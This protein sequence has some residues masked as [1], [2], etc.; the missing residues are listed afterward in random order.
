MNVWVALRTVKKKTVQYLK[1]HHI[2]DNA[3]TF[4]VKA[5]S[6]ATGD[7]NFGGAYPFG[8]T[9]GDIANAGVTSSAS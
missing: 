6:S 4:D 2:T 9:A 8:M 3:P 7:T 5:E 1:L